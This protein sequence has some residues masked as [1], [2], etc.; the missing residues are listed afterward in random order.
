MDSKFLT[1]IMILCHGM[2]AFNTIFLSQ[3]VFYTNIINTIN[4]YTFIVC[5]LKLLCYGHKR[6]KG[7]LN[8]FNF[9]LSPVT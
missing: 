6:N 7:K 9:P 2:Q 8:Y 3:H 1:K 4:L 5:I